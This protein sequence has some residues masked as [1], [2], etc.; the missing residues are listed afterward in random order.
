VNTYVMTDGDMLAF[1]GARS[2]DF[3][4]IGEG[5]GLVEVKGP[6]ESQE[7]GPTTVGRIVI[8]EGDAVIVAPTAPTPRKTPRLS[9]SMTRGLGVY[10]GSNERWHIFQP[11]IRHERDGDMLRIFGPINREGQTVEP[12]TALFW[13]KVGDRFGTNGEADQIPSR[14]AIPEP[15][16]PP[17]PF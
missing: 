3:S 10:V 9:S 1:Q 16:D 6:E 15:I 12:L 7:Q 13:L 8:G 2:F 17:F 14:S 5:K 11:A 4:V